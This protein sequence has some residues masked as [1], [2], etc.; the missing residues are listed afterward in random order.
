LRTR[1]REFGLPGFRGFREDAGLSQQ[2]LG[3][4]A[5]LHPTYFNGIERGQRNVSLLDIYAL[6][7][8]SS[9]PVG[10]LFA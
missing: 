1:L 4:R 7:E 2:D 10:N 9:V 8:G 6:A 5:G 3:F